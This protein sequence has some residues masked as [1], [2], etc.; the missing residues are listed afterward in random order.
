MWGESGFPY[1]L[2][3]TV[4]QVPRTLGSACFAVVCSNCHELEMRFKHPRKDWQALVVYDGRF[5]LH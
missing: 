3:L 1:L 2:A 4:V 5:L